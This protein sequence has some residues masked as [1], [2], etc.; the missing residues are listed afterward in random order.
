MLSSAV[1]WANLSNRHGRRVCLLTGLAVN[2][3][4]TA[5]I[6]FCTDYWVTF[7][8][9]LTSGFLNCNLPIM[10]TALRESFYHEDEDDTSAFST[11]SVAFGASCVAGPALGGIFYGKVLPVPLFEGFETPW[12]TPMLCCTLLYAIALVVTA[13]SMPETAFLSEEVVK[14]KG[15]KSK[16][17]KTKREVT[18]SSKLFRDPAFL[19]LLINAGG[20]SYVFT[21][22][23]LV[24]PLLARVSKEAGGEAWSTAHIGVTFLVGSVGLMI[25][26]LAIYPKLAKKMPVMRLWI[27]SWVYPAIIFPLFPRVLTRACRD[28]LPTQGW[29]VQL[30]NYGTQLVVSV[31]LGSGFISIQLLMNVYVSKLPGK[32]A[33]LALAN[34]WMVSTQAFVRAV[35]PMCT[36]SLFSIG[37][38]AETQNISF[39]NRSLP[40]DSLTAIGLVTGVFCGFAFEK[41]YVS[42]QA[43]RVGPAA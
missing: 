42:K 40:F 6:A 2:M 43:A 37:M 41:V 3:V 35:S 38:H 24:Y 34:S 14:S 12:M 21:G 25:Y 39:I 8:F 10:R 4:V 33:A 11:L 30:L 18:D 23:E 31:L 26:S 27:W 13:N 15:V 9:R 16:G 5:A 19:L 17:E 1:F 36:G 20:H 22:W 28:G 29:Q 32:N 7:A